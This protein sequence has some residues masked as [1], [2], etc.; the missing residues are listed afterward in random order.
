M[1][2]EVKS[3]VSIAE[4]Q[5]ASRSRAQADEKDA[6]NQA[7]PEQFD[8]PAENVA[9]FALSGPSAGSPIKG[10]ELFGA[11][12]Q[13]LEKREQFSAARLPE[14]LP[15]S[16]VESKDLRHLNPNARDN[17]YSAVLRPGH[18]FSAPGRYHDVTDVENKYDV[19]PNDVLPEGKYV[20]SERYLLSAFERGIDVE[21][22]R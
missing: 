4:A 18:V 3:N 8:A 7:G 22:K 20:V 21:Q 17:L 14:R 13:G 16:V 6:G 19:M 12:D 1:A 10:E 9:T 11:F 5:A 15:R 2:N